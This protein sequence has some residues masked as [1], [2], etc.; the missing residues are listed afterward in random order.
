MTA[1]NDISPLLQT[2]YPLA[3]ATYDRQQLWATLLPTLD[4]WLLEKQSRNYYLDRCRV[5]LDALDQCEGH[6]LQDRWQ[7]FEQTVLPQWSA[8][9]RDPRMRST[10]RVG[11]NVLVL[12][13]FILPGW[14][15]LYRLR[16]ND[17]MKKIPETC[18]LKQQYYLLKQSVDGLGWA[19]NPTKRGLA[20]DRGIKV[21]LVRGY[22]SLT[23]IQEAD[24]FNDSRSEPFGYL[25][26]GS[27]ILDGALC[28]LG[29]FERTPRRNS[30]RRLRQRKLTIPELVTKAN[31]L[32]PFDQLTQHYLETAVVRLNWT[33][34]HVGNM[35]Q[36][37]A[38][39]WHYLN[40]YHPEIDHPTQIMPSHGRAFIEHAIQ[41]YFKR[42]RFGLFQR[43]ENSRI[44]R[45]PVQLCV[46]DERFG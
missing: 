35:C 30:S 43:T 42:L 8:G 44:T 39:F 1:P 10:W 7:Y 21:M 16:I 32:P 18:S 29:V 31:I 24:L 34:G 23:E 3:V 19:K 22:E 11:I 14:I 2:R 38:A 40:Q 4:T 45:F 27:D 20:V 17:V 26:V 33:H 5:T 37:I 12:G 9:E 25:G 13:R 46:L 41:V 28:Q 6:R 36:S 15:S